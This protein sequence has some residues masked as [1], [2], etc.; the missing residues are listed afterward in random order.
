MATWQSKRHFGHSTYTV[1][2]RLSKRF[3]VIDKNASRCCSWEISFPAFLG[4]KN[5]SFVLVS[6]MSAPLLYLCCLNMCQM[7]WSVSPIS[8]SANARFLQLMAEEGANSSPT[9][10]TSAGP[11]HAN[12][13]PEG[14]CVSRKTEWP[15]SSPRETLRSKP[16]ALL[17]AVDTCNNGLHVADMKYRS[18]S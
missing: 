8:L 4:L 18:I 2:S 15:N 11:H 9:V 5:Q 16:K 10:N 17:R 13:F 12:S 6:W 1:C 14:T 7:D 3:Y